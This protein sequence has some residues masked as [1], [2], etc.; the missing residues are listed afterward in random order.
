VQTGAAAQQDKT[1][2]QQAGKRVDK[3]GGEP[4]IFHFCVG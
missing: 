3:I 4:V 2:N 1:K